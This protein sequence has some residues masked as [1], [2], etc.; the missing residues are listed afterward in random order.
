MGIHSHS[1]IL[2][3]LLQDAV[4][5]PDLLLC[6]NFDPP[7][8][9]P[10]PSQLH[11]CHYSHHSSWSHPLLSDSCSGH[12]YCSCWC[13]CQGSCSCFWSSHSCYRCQQEQEQQRQ[14]RSRGNPSKL[15]GS[16][17]CGE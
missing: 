12:W 1:L 9:S 3:L 14:E 4:S 7:L 13:S 5:L 8:S 17:R 16:C 10:Q 6:G 15:G 2:A 11:I